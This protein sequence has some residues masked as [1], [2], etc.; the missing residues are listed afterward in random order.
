MDKTTTQRLKQD[1]LGVRLLETPAKDSEYWLFGSP[2]ASAATLRTLPS[3]LGLDWA[4]RGDELIVDFIDGP[5]SGESDLVGWTEF[6]QIAAGSDRLLVR[7]AGHRLPVRVIVCPGLGVRVAI[8]H[9]D[10][11]E[12]RTLHNGVVERFVEPAI[13]RMDRHP[14]MVGCD[15]RGIIQHNPERILDHRNDLGTSILC[16]DFLLTHR[17]I[18]LSGVEHDSNQTVHMYDGL[19]LI[20]SSESGP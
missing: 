16:P 18:V 5:E 3:L 8:E 7:W 12:L 15:T 6:A 19:C 2:A 13:E 9:M 4:W 20:R 1:L 10:E 11:G 14:F 17:A